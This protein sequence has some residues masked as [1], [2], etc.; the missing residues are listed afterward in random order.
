MHSISNTVERK[1]I[2]SIDLSDLE[3]E[4]DSG[5][6]PISA[7]HKTVEYTVWHLE[8]ESGLSLDCADTHIVFDNN[9]NE[10][11]VKDDQQ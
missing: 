4:T 1:F 9:L 7:I 6:Q 2:D 11:F 3:I 8:T 10:I 5:W